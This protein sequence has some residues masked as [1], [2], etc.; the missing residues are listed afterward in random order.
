MDAIKFVENFEIYREQGVVK[1]DG[2]ICRDEV[3]D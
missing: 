3:L 1:C 2:L